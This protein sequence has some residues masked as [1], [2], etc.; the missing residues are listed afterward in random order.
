MTNIPE[1]PATQ[2]H[3]MN[4]PKTTVVECYTSD[5]S[6]IVSFLILPTTTKICCW[7]FSTG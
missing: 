7:M 2:I 3:Y 6:F 4:T 1:K 5:S